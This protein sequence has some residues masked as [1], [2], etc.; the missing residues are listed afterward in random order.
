V[1]LKIRRV[2]ELTR[3]FHEIIVRIRT[4]RT[5]LRFLTR[6]K[7]QQLGPEEKRMKVRELVSFL[8]TEDPKTGYSAAILTLTVCAGLIVGVL[9][10]G[11]TLAKALFADTPTVETTHS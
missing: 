8:F 6:H 3:P 7:T 10:G 11:A 5:M 1:T 2:G 4:D 9:Y